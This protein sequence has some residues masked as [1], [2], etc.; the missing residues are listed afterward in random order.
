MGHSSRGKDTCML[1]IICTCMRCSTSSARWR[2]SSSCVS[3]M[4]EV[5]ESFSSM[6]CSRPSLPTTN[7]SA[8]TSSPPNISLTLT[9]DYYSLTTYYKRI[10]ALYFKDCSEYYTVKENFNYLDYLCCYFIRNFLVYCLRKIFYRI[11]VSLLM[12]I[13]QA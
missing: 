9:S 4:K 1:N 5:A 10:H 7:S 3:P 13:E 2:R 12:F 11:S 8:Q 6:M